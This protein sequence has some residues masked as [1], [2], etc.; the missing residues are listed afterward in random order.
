M[1]ALGEMKLIALCSK[2][3]RGDRGRA[4]RPIEELLGKPRK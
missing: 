2:A 4:G 3:R 1:V